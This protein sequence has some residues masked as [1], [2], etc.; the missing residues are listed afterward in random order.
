MLMQEATPEMVETW[1]SIFA[2]YKTRL[3]PNR[4]KAQ[5][6][7]EYLEDKY[8]LEELTGGEWKQL[9]IDTVL[10]NEF[11]SKKLSAGKTVI[12][13][14]YRVL[15]EGNAQ[16]LY[17]QQDEVFKG[18]DIILGID[19]ETGFF[20]VEGSSLLWD[21]LFA[22]RGLDEDDLNNYYLVAEYISCLKR[23]DMLDDVLKG[24]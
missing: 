22:F 1:K 23:F 19:L 5:G 21:E 15:N 20:D 12:P 8:R 2:E 16:P 13:K 3:C 10:L 14:V 17:R 24:N 9:V 18:K 4:K 11:Y 7:I 6:I